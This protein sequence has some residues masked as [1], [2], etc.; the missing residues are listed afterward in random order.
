[1][2]ELNDMTP[3]QRYE[4]RKAARKARDGSASSQTEL[5]MMDIFDRFTTAAE[6][7]A[8]AMESANKRTG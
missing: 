6:R 5:E 2:T 8:D 3:K 1:M 7:I 4:A